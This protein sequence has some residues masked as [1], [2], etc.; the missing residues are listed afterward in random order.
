MSI[1]L[2]SKAFNA[3][4]LTSTQ[5]LLLLALADHANDEGN[6]VYPG[7][8]RLMLKTSM[9]RTTVRDT[10]KALYDIDI[11]Q[12]VRE[13]TPSSSTEYR[14]NTVKLDE[15]VNLTDDDDPSLPTP[16]SSQN[17]PQQAQG[18]GRQ[19][20]QGHLPQEGRQPT[21]GRQT[22][23]GEGRHATQGGSPNDPGRVASR[24]RIFN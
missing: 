2:M 16:P 18:E 1:L 21:L 15:L 13:A 10:L 20:T 14:I 9:S 11:L 19:P 7:Q 3:K 22:T 17:P 5:K 12:V 23:Q 4:R 24:P 6:H 8:S